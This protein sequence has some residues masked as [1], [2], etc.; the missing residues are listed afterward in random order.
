MHRLDTP[1]KLPLYENIHILK[2]I[3]EVSPCEVVVNG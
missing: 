1:H 3:R 2:A